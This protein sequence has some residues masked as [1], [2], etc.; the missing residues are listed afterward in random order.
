MIQNHRT[1]ARSL[2]SSLKAEMKLVAIQSSVTGGD[3]RT[4]KKILC[5]R[6]TM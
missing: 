3:R 6:K 4:L 5:I 1:Q 2:F